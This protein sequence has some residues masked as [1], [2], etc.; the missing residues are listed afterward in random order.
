MARENSS[1]SPQRGD[2]GGPEG[3]SMPPNDETLPG[4]IH[5]TFAEYIDR[6]N[7]GDV[8]DPE[9]IRR[10][11]PECAE[12]LISQLQHFGGFG[13]SDKGVARAFGSYRIDGELGRG[14][15]GV[16]YDAFDA[17]M[18]RRVALKVLSAGLAVDP[19]SVERF[20][21]EARIVG[22]LRHPN[23]V[24]VY[25]TGLQDG[26]PYIAMEFVE[27]ES[28][29]KVLERKRPQADGRPPSSATDPTQIVEADASAA[30]KPSTDASR[31][32]ESRSP[33]PATSADM[34]LSYCIRMAKIFAAVA[35]GL[36]HAHTNDIVHRDLKPSNLILDPENNLRILDFGL[37]RLEGQEHLTGSGELLG[38]PRYMSP[39]QAQPTHEKIDHRT[40]L[41]SLGATLYE[42]LTL[43]PPFQ[44]RTA[45]ETLNAIV[46][47]QPRA[48]ERVNPRVPRDLDTIVLK[49]LRKNPSDRYETAA[50]LAGD[51]RRF[52]RGDPIKARPRTL[53]ER[54]AWW[55]R[56]HWSRVAAV[57]VVALAVVFAAGFFRESG[58]RRAA[59]YEDIVTD[60]AVRL[61]RSGALAD[62]AG[63]FAWDGATYNAFLL[64]EG[65][66]EGDVVQRP[67]LEDSVEMLRRAVRSVPDRPSAHFHLAHAL[68]TNGEF[69]LAEESLQ[70]AIDLGF[71]PAQV[72]RVSLLQARGEGDAAQARLEEVLEQASARPEYAWVE[73]WVE[74]LTA[75]RQ[76]DWAKAVAAYEHLLRLETERNEPL[77]LGSTVEFY[78]SLGFAHLEL[79]DYEDARS[80][81]SAT[82]GLRPGAV[83]PELFTAISYYL[84]GDRERADGL[85][86][87]LYLK[88]PSEDLAY[89]VTMLF[90]ARFQ[91]PQRGLKWSERLEPGFH[92]EF[93]R[94]N[95]LNSAGRSLEALEIARELPRLKPQ[96][97]LAHFV[98]ALICITN[99]ELEEGEHAAREA[100]RL[101]PKSSA[102]CTV[103]SWSLSLQGKRFEALQ[104]LQQAIELEPDA[105]EPRFY[106]G[107]AQ[108]YMGL[109][110][111]AKANVEGALRDAKKARVSMLLFD[112]SH[113][114][115]GELYLR[116]GEFEDALRHFHEAVPLMRKRGPV[117]PARISQVV[118]LEWEHGE[119]L[120][121]LELLDETLD[122]GVARESDLHTL[123]TLY[124]EYAQQLLPDM[125]TLRA[126]EA[127]YQAQ[128][129]REIQPAN[130]TWKFFR[131]RSAPSDGVDWA[132]PDFDDT[133]W[134]LGEGGFGY[135]DQHSGTLI[136]DMRGAYTSL[137]LRATVELPNELE[138]AKL[139]LRVASDDGFVAFVDGVEVGRARLGD[140]AI[141]SVD[142]EPT[143]YADEPPVPIEFELDPAEFAARRV[144]VAVHGLNKGVNSS[145]FLLR[146]VVAAVTTSPPTFPG[147]GTG[148]MAESQSA[149][150]R[151]RVHEDAGRLSE[152]A[153]EFSRAQSGLRD[154]LRGQLAREA[155]V[156]VLVR[157]RRFKEALAEVESQLAAACPGARATWETWSAL[158]FGS[159][160]QSLTE[161]EEAIPCVDWRSASAT[162]GAAPVESY[163]EL[164]RGHLDTLRRGDAVRINSGGG[165]LRDGEHLWMSDRFFSG[166][167]VVSSSPSGS[168][169]SATE[170]LSWVD[171]TS[172]RFGPPH[173]DG[174]YILPMPRGRYR[175]LVR[176]R[177]LS[178]PE[179]SDAAGPQ[180]TAEGQLVEPKVRE[181]TAERRELELEVDVDDGLL[182][183]EFGATAQ[184]VTRVHIQALD[185]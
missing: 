65:L 133:D 99:G 112:Q 93:W 102:P 2:H 183:L 177:Q 23:I 38:T 172:R 163:A 59:E 44:G 114:Q 36:E 46:R 16:V 82:R 165:T 169:S 94:A 10:D 150:F 130:A 111:K 157:M 66:D 4:E 122:A 145:D 3:E 136:D 149:Y 139:V 106:L 55:L 174:A 92:Q 88:N 19:R 39:E 104:A 32:V 179:A 48:P 64:A 164:L 69:V 113:W 72:V 53:T 83:E 5:A 40:D 162:F 60:A 37:A 86:D 97:A 135:G 61:Q 141:V 26:T 148:G 74:A 90:W 170:D 8:L 109:G 76:R 137:Y 138:I 125:P 21:R 1:S 95:F 12:E 42:V 71:L 121:A 15:M 25:S 103:L 158:S 160:A 56:Q 101:A 57:L 118:R 35:E 49:C 151:G 175:V 41:Y 13:A 144:V 159:L 117:A 180:I 34:D 116:E 154:G 119:R 161:A 156:R 31:Q 166:G 43:S 9:A 78:M 153:S 79:G 73:R 126:V 100:Q 85:F 58:R 128:R 62:R 167:R 7:R 110:S 89:T 22:K 70:R 181:L 129:V 178:E 52:S 171:R 50:E 24:S 27:G 30:E 17:E 28:L 51:L 91:D 63:L 14:G 54:A 155:L 127:Y 81:F 80:S 147:T 67:H 173:A 185:P 152:A 75:A 143:H 142:H 107:I 47:Q 87:K 132:R 11:H 176:L 105:A 168:S 33:I 131:G 20:R 115:V 98:T 124:G 140:A 184:W 18:D 29:E 182:N 84:E 120:R 123:N 134:E 68:A 146:P 96:A 77:Y 108:W 45:Q 6:L